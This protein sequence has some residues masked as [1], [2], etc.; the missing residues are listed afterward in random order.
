MGSCTDEVV[1]PNRYGDVWGLPSYQPEKLRSISAS[2]LMR[3]ASRLSPNLS[4]NSV[5]PIDPDRFKIFTS[6]AVYEA[7]RAW[8]A[9]PLRQT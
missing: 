1:H 3:S 6:V 9:W 8:A 4:K 5:T 7:Y 2:V